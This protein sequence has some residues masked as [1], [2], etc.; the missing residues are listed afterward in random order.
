MTNFFASCELLCEE[1]GEV[2]VINF[3]PFFLGKYCQEIL[4][5]KNPP[6]NSLSKYSNFITLNFWERFCAKIA[7]LNRSGASHKRSETSE[8]FAQEKSL[9]FQRS[10]ALK[11]EDISLTCE[12]VLS[13]NPP[14]PTPLDLSPTH[15]D[16]FAGSRFRVVCRADF[17]SRQALGSE[18]VPN[19]LENA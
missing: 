10:A 7:F 17:E 12:D 11:I 14:N 3:K 4:P 5:P 13:Y 9:M 6:H 18:S 16:T 8:S 1:C 15:T 19:Q 2:L